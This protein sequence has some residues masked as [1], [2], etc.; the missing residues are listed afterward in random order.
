MLSRN[1]FLLIIIILISSFQY[2]TSQ[3]SKNLYVEYE[4]LFNPGITIEKEAILISNGV[5]SF[6]RTLD[7]SS[8]E[9]ITESND[10][11]IHVIAK[12][13][14]ELI[15][16]DLLSDSIYIISSIED[17]KYKIIDNFN[18]LNWEL[19]SDQSKLINGIEVYK[20]TTNFRGR[21]YSAWY[22]PKIPVQ[23]GP[24]KFG[25]LPGLIIEIFDNDNKFR[26]LAKAIKYPY[27][28]EKDFSVPNSENLKDISFRGYVDLKSNIKADKQ[29]MKMARA[30]QGVKLISSKSA[31]GIELLYE[32][33]KE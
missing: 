16:N 11:N 24:W 7:S 29:K 3:E 30:P 21:K 14:V 22:N 4:V 19:Q 20:A 5:T 17:K 26:W 15:Y 28:L 18:S 13:T 9:K 6:Y 8:D 12:G 27:K 2:I 31:R 33:E 23:A 32:W 10:G 25:G 1:G